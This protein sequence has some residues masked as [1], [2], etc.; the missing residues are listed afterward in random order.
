MSVLPVIDEEE[1]IGCGTC[2]DECHAE[3]LV[4]SGGKASFHEHNQCNYCGICDVV[5]PA[6]AIV[7]AYV[8]RG[9]E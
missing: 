5:C 1:C 2:V 8:I 9:E 6:S 3:A 7:C 4:L